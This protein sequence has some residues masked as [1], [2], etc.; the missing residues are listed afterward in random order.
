MAEARHR[1]RESANSF[2][3]VPGAA[4]RCRAARADDLAAPPATEA[5]PTRA[6]RASPTAP[7]RLCRF[8]AR[9]GA[10]RLLPR[11]VCADSLHALVALHIH[12]RALC[13]AAQGERA[14][15][16]T[17]R[18][19]NLLWNGRSHCAEAPVAQTSKAGGATH[20][21]RAQRDADPSRRVPARR[22]GLRHPSRMRS[23]L[24]RSVGTVVC[25]FSARSS[26]ALAVP[27]PPYRLAR[28]RRNSCSSA[29]TRS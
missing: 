26:P 1:A 9:P 14:S 20:R 4:A 22:H 27:A 11:H 10:P 23:G 15:L 16:L 21:P 13:R 7:T 28:S 6:R 5:L 19:P 8:V 17:M 25:V 24:R 3:R 2:L 29:T 18:R 12:G